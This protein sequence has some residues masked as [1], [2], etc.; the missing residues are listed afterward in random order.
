MTKRQRGAAI[1]QF[2]DDITDFKE[3]FA[4]CGFDVG[5]VKQRDLHIPL[6]KL[7]G[8]DELTQI[9]AII[10]ICAI[11]RVRFGK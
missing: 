9:L 2:F 3:E 4:T 10:K 6:E 5:K 8:K 1:E 11:K 7:A